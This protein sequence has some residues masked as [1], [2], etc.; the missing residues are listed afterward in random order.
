MMR[1]IF[2]NVLVVL[3]ILAACQ[4]SDGTS[5]STADVTEDV[6]VT[7]AVEET[8]ELLPTEDTST[9]DD[10]DG[11][12]T[13]DDLEPVETPDV[14][15]TAEPAETAEPGTIDNPFSPLDGTF[16]I[17]I[18]RADIT[19]GLNVE[20]ADDATIWVLLTVSLSNSS[21]ASISIGEDDLVIIGDDEQRYMPQPMAERVQPALVGYELPSEETVYGSAL[22]ALPE[23]VEPILVEWCPT[24]NCNQPLQ[25]EI[26]TAP[27]P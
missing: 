20:E 13:P 14:S 9:T 16:S 23:G 5:V 11:S 6:S 2:A 12:D 1:A 15:E 17:G 3:L 10:A 4:S 26:L 7:E 8:V 19:E 27:R 18:P 21:D 25:I 22:F 24:G